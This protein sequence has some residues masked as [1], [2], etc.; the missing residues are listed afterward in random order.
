MAPKKPYI[1]FSI[2]YDVVSARE[3]RERIQELL[4]GKALSQE[5]LRSPVDRFCLE[6]LGSP[7]NIPFTIQEQMWTALLFKKAVNAENPE[8]SR[9]SS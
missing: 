3:D 8:P 2:L 5:E 1:P 7:T 9:R 6:R 4:A